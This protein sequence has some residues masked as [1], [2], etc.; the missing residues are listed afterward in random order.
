MDYDAKYQ[1]NLE[2]IR[3]DLAR[4]EKEILAISKKHTMTQGDSE[5]LEE[6]GTFIDWA[7]NRPGNYSEEDLKSLRSG[8][9]PTPGS[10]PS[11]GKPYRTF[12]EQ[13][14]AVYRAGLPNGQVD[15][16]LY[17]IRAAGLQEAVPSEGG[18]LCQTD[19]TSELIRSLFQPGRLP[20]LVRRYPINSASN[21]MTM[22]GIDE[23]SRVSSRFGGV[24]AYWE[25]EAAE[26]SLSKP[27][28]RK[29]ELALKKLIGLCYSSDE[30]LE[31]VPALGQFL[32]EAFN[33]E[34]QFQ[35]ENVILNGSG[36]GQPLG[37]LTSGALVSIGK[38][39]GQTADTI[40]WAN[41]VKMLA[42]FKPLNV[43]RACWVANVD[44]LP[45]LLQMNQAVGTAGIPVYIA[46]N[47]QGGGVSSLCG[48][49]IIWS[50]ASPTLGDAGDLLLCDP[51]A[52]LLAD[53]GGI[54]A[55]SSI[56]VRFVYDETAFRFVYRVDGQPLFAS[57]VTPFK[58]SATVSPFVA[59]AAR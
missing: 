58:G 25:S 48:F 44:T 29:I 56:H 23:T 39:T 4:A 36:A 53:K 45:Q 16:R 50:E 32:T 22:P 37:I 41:I 18:F 33:A 19:F 1:G 54:Q 27:K 2:W 3:A 30:L 24:V 17:Q 10:G 38:E 52:Y 49:P 28:F 12:G 14:F 43:A 42:R 59:I 7:E 51:T 8:G 34:F 40:L 31:D 6:L 13:M 55:V 11:G 5:R 57:P 20:A 15:P 9:F 35:L 26:K 21:K 46:G 47:I